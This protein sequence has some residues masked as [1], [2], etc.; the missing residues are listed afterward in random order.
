MLD[1]LRFVGIKSIVLGCFN[2]SHKLN[3]VVSY[4]VQQCWLWS[5]SR[6][7][8]SAFIVPDNI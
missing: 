3:I 6:I 4:P 8:S 5:S 7:N 1:N 2:R